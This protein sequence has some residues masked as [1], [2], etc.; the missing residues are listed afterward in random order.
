MSAYD[1]SQLNA[2]LVVFLV[3]VGA[4][5]VVAIGSSIHRLFYASKTGSDSG[6]KAPSK[7][8]EDYMRQLRMRN[9][10]HAWSEAREAG[11]VPS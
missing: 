8:Q 11:P 1:G 10:M 5:A 9:R 7:E 4:A 6:F 3:I 2:P